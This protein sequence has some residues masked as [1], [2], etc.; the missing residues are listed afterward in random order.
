[1]VSSLKQTSQE[2]APAKRTGHLITYFISSMNNFS[3]GRGLLSFHGYISFLIFVCYVSLALVQGDLIKYMGSFQSSCTVWGLFCYRL[4][5]HFGEGT[6]R[7]WEEGIFFDLGW[8]I[9]YI[10]IQSICFITSLSFTVYLVYLFSFCFSDLHISE[11][12][13]AKSPNIIVWDS[14][15]V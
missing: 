14:M 7:S 4:Y 3:L 9:L 15:C 6:M 1:M 13:A 2:S 10:S 8:N 11:R 5:G 12:G